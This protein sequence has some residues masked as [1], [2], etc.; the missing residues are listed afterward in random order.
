MTRIAPR[1]ACWLLAGGGALLA[2]GCAVYDTG[3]YGDASYGY[4]NYGAYPS[5][6]SGTVYVPSAPATVYYYQNDVYYP[7]QP[8]YYG[9]DY[10]VYPAGPRPHYSPGYLPR[11]PANYAPRPPQ[12]SDGSQGHHG[13]R[14]PVRPQQP[15]PPRLDR[16]FQSA[17][18]TQQPNGNNRPWLTP[19][20]P[21]ST[22][23]TIRTGPL[24]AQ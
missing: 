2:S 1:L 9:P 4:P 10:P 5:V 18:S 3:Y 15:Q 22:G 24:P 11:P 17:P 14:P 12:Y 8:A 23:V 7:R 6:Q 16:P 20:G 13:R 21:S 19:S